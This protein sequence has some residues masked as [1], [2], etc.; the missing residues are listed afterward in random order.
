MTIYDEKVE[1]VEKVDGAT[2]DLDV[3]AYAK[4]IIASKIEMKAIQDD[5]KVIKS[6]AK[7]NGI[8]IKEIDAVIA[9]LL[10]EM[11]K[12]PSES[13]IEDGIRVK[14]EANEDVMASLSLLV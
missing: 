11:K 3:F 12:D 1:T 8:L 7:E 2:E 14:I 13:M 6:E 9:D 4:S 10:R 5:I